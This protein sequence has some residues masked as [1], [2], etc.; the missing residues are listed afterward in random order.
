MRTFYFVGGPT[1]GNRE[2]FFCRLEAA[3]GLPAGWSV[4][5]HISGDDE[6]LH[7]VRVDSESA[8]AA[9]LALFADIYE[10]TKPIEVVDGH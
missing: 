3:A 5:P 4:Y 1:P 9:H 7:I 8:I 6:A 2:V 10:C